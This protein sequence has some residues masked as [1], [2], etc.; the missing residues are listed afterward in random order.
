MVL[1]RKEAL[2][3]LVFGS[4]TVVSVGTHQQASVLDL[5]MH[6]SE[7]LV[8]GRAMNSGIRT[9]FFSDLLCLRIAIVQLLPKLLGGLISKLRDGPR[10]LHGAIITTSSSPLLEFEASWSTILIRACVDW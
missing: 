10:S 7:I 9:L 8:F 2:W 6:P 4:A 5:H 3:G 1:I